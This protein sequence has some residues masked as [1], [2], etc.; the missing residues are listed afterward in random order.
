MAH[1]GAHGA[2]DD[3]EFHGRRVFGDFEGGAAERYFGFLLGLAPVHTPRSPNRL[4]RHQV[5]HA[6]RGSDGSPLIGKIPD[7]VAT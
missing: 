4:L 5:P 3:G 1:R 6:Q 7:P 2:A